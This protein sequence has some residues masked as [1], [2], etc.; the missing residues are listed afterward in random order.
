MTCHRYSKTLPDV[1]SLSGVSNTHVK[2][3][4]YSTFDLSQ[5][6]SLET[7]NCAQQGAARTRG[8]LSFWKS[9]VHALAIARS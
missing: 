9:S 6:C 4:S 3:R 5:I 7:A 1:K 2:N 8:T